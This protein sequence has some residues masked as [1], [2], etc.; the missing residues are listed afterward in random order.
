[1]ILSEYYNK[2]A[3]ESNFKKLFYSLAGLMLIVMTLSSS[4]YGICWD[5]ALMAEYGNS[6]LKFYTSLGKTNQ[7]CFIGTAPMHY[8]GAF[9]DLLAAIINLGNDGDIY[10]RRHFLIAVFGFLGIL[11]T[12]LTAKELANWKLAVLSILFLFLSPVYFGHSMFNSKDIPFAAAYIASVYYIIRFVKEFP[13]FSWSTLIGL[14][15]SIG[16]AVSIRF[17]GILLYLYLGVFILIKFW[18]FK[19]ALR[20][21]LLKNKEL[22]ITLLIV[23]IGSYCFALLFWPYALISPLKHPFE[24]TAFYSKIKFDSGSLFNGGRPHY[25]EIPWNYLPMWIYVTTPLF[26][27]ISIIYSPILIFNWKKFNEVVN[28]KLFLMVAF[29]SIFPVAYIVFK[30]AIVFDSWRH[31]TFIYPSLVVC[32]ASIWYGLIHLFQNVLKPIKYITIVVLIGSMLEPAMYMVKHHKFETFYFS[33]AIGGI[34]G[35]FKKFDIDYYGT[36]LR[37]AVEWIAENS[38]TLQ[39]GPNGKIRIRCFY[40][41]P[42]SVIHFIQK[43]PM[44]EFVRTQEGSVDYEYSIIQPVQSKFDESLLTNWPPKGMIHQI[45]IDGTPIVAIVKNYNKK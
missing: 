18:S 10:I 29:T 19:P 27:C 23:F 40:G 45:E 39:K 35:A 36:S 7:T 42:I 31:V 38:D 3:T 6:T 4:Q 32:C 21:L 11:F 24:A 14:I 13:T 17:G 9:F 25:W 33:P 37:Y 12:G 44:L 22:I 41:E 28:G 20:K 26:I 1:M 5:E 8:Y 16:I 15:I 2:A 34:P 43:Y 30:D